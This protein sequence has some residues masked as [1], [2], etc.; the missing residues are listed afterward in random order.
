MYAAIINQ[1]R[2]LPDTPPEEFDTCQEAWQY[3]VSELEFDW[4]IEETQIKNFDH[5]YLEAHT[6]MHSLNQNLPGIVYA[7]N[8]VYSV[9][10]I[11]HD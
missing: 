2:Y 6:E 7:G 9:E 3:L 1:P 10:Y 4:E 8:Y 5:N 11:S